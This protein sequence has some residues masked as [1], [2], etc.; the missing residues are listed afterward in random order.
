MQVWRNKPH[1]ACMNDGLDDSVDSAKEIARLQKLFDK[2]LPNPSR[3]E[4]RPIQ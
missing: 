3:A 4:K 1:C 2:E